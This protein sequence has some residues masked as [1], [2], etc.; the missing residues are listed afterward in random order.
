MSGPLSEPAARPAGTR[1]GHEVS[2]WPRQVWPT[3][4]RPPAV[5]R[6]RR[7]S[8]PAAGPAA[9]PG[10][11]RCF[12]YFDVE[13]RFIISGEQGRLSIAVRTAGWGMT[14]PHI[15]SRTFIRCRPVISRDTF[16]QRTQPMFSLPTSPHDGRP[17]ATLRRRRGHVC[18]IASACPHPPPGARNQKSRAGSLQTTAGRSHGE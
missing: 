4:Q 5:G 9:G 13:S 7:F 3:S 18:T 11:S 17:T 15:F 2:G 10:P 16:V 6:G 1:V 14:L 12:H 8:S